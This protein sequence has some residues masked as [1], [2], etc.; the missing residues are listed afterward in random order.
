MKP[1][2]HEEGAQPLPLQESKEEDGQLDNRQ[3]IILILRDTGKMILIRGVV[4]TT[5][6]AVN[7][8]LNHLDEDAA[9]SVSIVKGTLF[10]AILIPMSVPWAIFAMFS[11]LF[12]EIRKGT[13][14]PEDVGKL[15]RIATYVVAPVCTVVS[16]GFNF[17]VPRL[18]ASIENKA[19]KALRDAEA[20]LRIAALGIPGNFA[21]A[22]MQ[23]LLITKGYE[24]WAF[25]VNCLGFAELAGLG[26][27]LA[28]SCGLGP[29][30]VAI[31]W[32]IRPYLSL[33][34]SGSLLKALPDFKQY[35]LW[36]CGLSINLKQAFAKLDK[37]LIGAN[38]LHRTSEV[39][40]FLAGTIGASFFG[41][42]GLLAKNAYDTVV[43]FFTLLS[44]A[45]HITLMKLIKREHAK[46][47]YLNCKR[48]MHAMAPLSLL[49]STI[50][51]LTVGLNARQLVKVN[52]PHGTE[53]TPT[54]VRLL[55]IGAAVS[56]VDLNRNILLA[57]SFATKDPVRP[58]LYTTGAMWCFA[59][60][61]MFLLTFGF[62]VGIE[63][64]PTMILIG[65]TL[66]LGLIAKRWINGL[67]TR[68]ASMP[69][70]VALVSVATQARAA[71]RYSQLIEPLNPAGS[72][73]AGGVR[74][75]PVSSWFDTPTS[76]FGHAGRAVVRTVKSACCPSPSPVH[77]ALQ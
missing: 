41:E 73:S 50:L 24:W 27:Y 21:L 28:Y 66:G 35:K 51:G 54:M 53:V 6:T 19:P 16:V 49:T 63:N 34:L 61:I 23:S 31:A 74:P 7:L 40:V 76:F 36:Q 65:F 52:L 4:S 37:E 18:I 14:L 2:I 1:S 58:A 33:L 46:G 17:A 11:G 38:T 62:E 48:I 68:L 13:R 25:A 69:E 45:I 55:K 26:Y 75:Q 72:D 70:P 67:N 5:F 59:I 47:H 8:L 32:T 44:F 77:P 29:A 3:M 10:T 42:Q 12:G 9:A 15:Y 39:L 30:G 22:P 43:H 56:T 71:E 20:F 60:P 64:I 57:G